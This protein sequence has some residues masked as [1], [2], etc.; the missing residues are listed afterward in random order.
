MAQKAAQ[1]AATLVFCSQLAVF[2]WYLPQGFEQAKSIIL[3]GVSLLIL[4]SASAVGNT[5]AK[6]FTKFKELSFY[7]RLF[8][9]ALVLI[10]II[11]GLVEASDLELALVGSQFRL[12]GF[13]ASVFG[14]LIIFCSFFFYG[15]NSKPQELVHLLQ[16]YLAILFVQ[17]VIGWRDFFALGGFEAISS[18]LVNGNYGQANF[19]GSTML[20]GLLLSGYSFLNTGEVKSR[21]LY[22]LL[23]IFF[24]SALLISGSQAAIGGIVIV[25]MLL[26]V[27]RMISSLEQVKTNHADKL[28]LSLGI[29]LTIAIVTATAAGYLWN[30]SR[31]LFWEA[32]LQLVFASPIFGYGGIDLISE[33]L[34]GA[35]LLPGRFIDRAHNFYLDLALAYGIIWAGLLLVWIVKYTIQGLRLPKT[36]LWL[37]IPVVVFLITSA[38]QTKSASQY[39][40]LALFLGLIAGVYETQRRAQ[41]VEGSISS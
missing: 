29:V 36:Q 8:F 1:I 23:A 41:L 38:V 25:L 32:S 35:G 31:S 7:K 33:A 6:L 18:E 11:S 20:T 13:V 9:L 2:W 39:Y 27:S 17:G 28:S 4:L 26:L 22:T 3:V 40:E 16:I 10:P 5:R 34:Q 30:P 15:K 37:V 24:C 12:F 19:F 14:P 21:L